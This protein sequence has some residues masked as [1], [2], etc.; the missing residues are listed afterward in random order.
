MADGYRSLESLF[1]QI[2][3]TIKHFTC[4]HLKEKQR[5]MDIQKGDEH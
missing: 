2:V 5:V 4:F 3:Y 1:T